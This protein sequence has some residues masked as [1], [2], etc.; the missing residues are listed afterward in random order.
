MKLLIMIKIQIFFATVK[1]VRTS[2]WNA[3]SL[4]KNGIYRCWTK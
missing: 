1:Y 3:M 2:K 4:K